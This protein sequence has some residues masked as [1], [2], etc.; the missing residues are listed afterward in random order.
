MQTEYLEVG[1]LISTFTSFFVVIWI[2]IGSIHLPSIYIYTIDM[3]DM[4]SYLHTTTT[5]IYRIE[6]IIVNSRNLR[7][8]MIIIYN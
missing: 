8:F 5:Y 4:L 1:Y 7:I 6:E 2:K 3:H